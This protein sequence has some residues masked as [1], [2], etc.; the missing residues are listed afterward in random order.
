MLKRFALAVAMGAVLLCGQEQ[1]TPAIF[2]P[3]VS[4]Y[5]E[6][7]QFVGLSDAQ[8][9]QLRAIAAEKDKAIQAAYQQIAAKQTQLNQ[10]L[11]SGSTDAVLIGQLTIEIRELRKKLPLPAEPWRSRALA[12]LTP[13]QKT[14]LVALDQANKLA[15]AARQAVT[16]SLVDPPPPGRPGILR[17][18]D[19]GDAVSVDPTTQP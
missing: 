6:L 11:Q 7:K 15:V 4:A 12:V 3:P 10:L 18:P 14:K 19:A 2:P 1:V 9:E 16:F 13:D 5:D 8:I 17:T